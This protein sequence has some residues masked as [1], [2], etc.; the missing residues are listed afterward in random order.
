MERKFNMVFSKPVILNLLVFLFA[1]VLLIAVPFWEK[2][3]QDGLQFNSK[4]MAAAPSQQPKPKSGSETSNTQVK[5]GSAYGKYAARGKVKLIMFEQWGCEYCEQ[6]LE[7]VGVVYPKTEEGKFAPLEMVDYRLAE[8][9]YNISGIVFTPTFVVIED[10][11][12]VGRI[13][14]YH[15]EDFFWQFLEEIFEKAGY[16]V[17]ATGESKSNISPAP[18]SATT[19]KKGKAG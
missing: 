1:L 7:E 10:G 18:A 17:A 14:G 13:V 6:W 4:T 3:S 19:P 16:V 5:T 15:S 9:D 2:S 8:S 11:K 12:E